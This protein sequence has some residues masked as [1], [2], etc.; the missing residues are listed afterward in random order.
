MGKVNV[1]HC[2]HLQQTCLGSNLHKKQIKCQDCGKVLLAW[3]CWETQQNLIT[4]ILGPH[5]YV[6]LFDVRVSEGS[7]SS[8]VRPPPPGADR[9]TPPTSDPWI[10]TD[11]TTPP[12]PW[13]CPDSEDTVDRGAQT[14]HVLYE[15][16]PSAAP[17]QVRDN[18]IELVASL[19]EILGRLLCPPR[20]R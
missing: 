5:G 3:W 7:T 14:G 8:E 10:C 15:K 20:A 6:P 18:K 9:T 17:A 11:S 1:P 12:G 4:K 19:F 13:I 16:V 2:M